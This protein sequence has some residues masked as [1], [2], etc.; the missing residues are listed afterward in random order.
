MQAPKGTAALIYIRNADS[1]DKIRISKEQTAASLLEFFTCCCI[2]PR[3]AVLYI[4]QHPFP[5][6]RCAWPD[7]I[8]GVFEQM[9]VSVM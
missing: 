8:G 1:I 4:G 9:R 2:V 5:L 6:A 7:S 3:H